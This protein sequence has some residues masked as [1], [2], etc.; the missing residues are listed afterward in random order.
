M[1]QYYEKKG[2]GLN[3]DILLK[4]VEDNIDDP[5]IKAFIKMELKS[6]YLFK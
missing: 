2:E 3:V 1:V 5:M 4:E 6:K